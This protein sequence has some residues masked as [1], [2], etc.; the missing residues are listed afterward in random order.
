VG[1][2]GYYLFYCDDSGVEF[3]DTYHD[4][5]DQALSQAE[6]EFRTKADEWEVAES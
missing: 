5:L 3:T 6:W 1:D 4:S 2:P